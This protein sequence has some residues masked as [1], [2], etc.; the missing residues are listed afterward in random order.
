[1]GSQLLTPDMK[2]W[3]EDVMLYLLFGDTALKGWSASRKK[4]IRRKVLKFQVGGCHTQ[5]K[6]R[7]RA[8]ESSESEYESDPPRVNK[9]IGDTERNVNQAKKRFALDE[10]SCIVL[11]T[12][13]PEVTHIVAWSMLD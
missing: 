12:N 13:A 11:G 2:I 7:K 9:K 5:F 1:L 8:H 6:S 3:Y 4:N 10:D